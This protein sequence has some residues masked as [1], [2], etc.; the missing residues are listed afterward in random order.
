MLELFCAQFLFVCYHNATSLASSGV[1]VFLAIVQ[2]CG[3]SGGFLADK[4]IGEWVESRGTGLLRSQSS[5]A[6]LYPN[7]QWVNQ[8]N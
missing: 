1:N 7:L 8:I 6:A 5:L 2:V 4:V 3:L